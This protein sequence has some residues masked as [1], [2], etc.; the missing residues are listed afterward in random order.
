MDLRLMRYFV[1]VAEELNFSRAAR[2]LNMAQPPLSQQIKLLESE[3]GVPLLKRDNRNVELT[4]PGKV[5]LEAARLTLLQADLAVQ[6]AQLAERGQIGELSI[7]FVG[8]A[9][10][11]ILV[12]KLKA[13]RDQYPSVHLIL[14]EMTT[15]EQLD[16]LH[17]RKIHAGFVRP[18]GHQPTIKSRVFTE[19]PL[20][21]ALPEFHALASLSEVSVLE[22]AEEPFIM[23]P[24][25]LGPDFYD[26]IIGFFRGHGASLRIVQE[27]VQ[28]HTIV[29]LAATGLGLA[30][31]PSSVR[32]FRRPGIVYRDFAEPSPKIQLLIAWREDDASP[33]LLAF[34]E[35]AGSALS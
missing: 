8:S 16:A 29:N 7:G 12:N 21:L 19:E 14:K 24:R 6:A 34:L 30:A 2:R 18:F 13:F 26:T 11:G 5:F 10:D 17:A 28:M 4:E 27:A 22:A 9:A 31:V 25:H 23:P 1:A 35:L 32:N 15:S 3:I 33:A 20:V